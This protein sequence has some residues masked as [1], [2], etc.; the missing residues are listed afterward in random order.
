MRDD[1][2]DRAVE[3]AR[4]RPFAVHAD[5][6]IPRIAKGNPDDRS[7]H[8][9]V[10]PGETTPANNDLPFAEPTLASTHESPREPVTTI[11]VGTFATACR[12]AGTALRRRILRFTAAGGDAFG[13]FLIVTRLA[14]I[15]Q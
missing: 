13:V 14:A 10:W 2:G 6:E 9:D 5:I 7:R 1:R 8:A 15:H 11:V 4:D 12:A 3:R